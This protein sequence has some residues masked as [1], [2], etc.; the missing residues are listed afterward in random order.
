MLEVNLFWPATTA[1]PAGDVQMSIL[2]LFLGH[3]IATLLL[4]R[5]V[6]VHV[7]VVM[8]IGPPLSQLVSLQ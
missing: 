1:I 2:R 8:Q 4:H 6:V 3:V 7:Q 5:K